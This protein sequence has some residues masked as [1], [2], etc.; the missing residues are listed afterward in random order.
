MGAA[1][2]AAR[3]CLGAPQ[4]CIDDKWWHYQVGLF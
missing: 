1:R 3:Q 4:N 2:L